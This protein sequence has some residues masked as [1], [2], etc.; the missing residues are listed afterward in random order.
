MSNTKSAVKKETAKAENVQAV[1]AAQIEKSTAKVDEIFNPSADDR[2]KK[3][4]TLNRLAEKKQKIDRKL[5]ELVNFNASND[6][7]QSEMTFSGH[8]G[9]RFTISN[10]VTIKKLLGFVEE[11]LNQL[12]EKTGKEIINFQI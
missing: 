4:E 2:I 7:T 12:K 11:E 3:L 9:Y 8:N 6:G 10:P 5:S 1:K